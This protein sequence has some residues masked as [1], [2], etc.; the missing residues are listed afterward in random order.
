MP[1]LNSLFGLA[2]AHDTHV[3]PQPTSLDRMFADLQKLGSQPPAPRP[4]A[5]T[6]AVRRVFYSFHYDD[7]F[8]VNHVRNA[9][10][11]RAVDRGRQLTPQDRSLWERVKRTNPANLRRVIDARLQ[12]TSVTCVLV[13]SETWEREWVRYEIARSFFRGNGLLAVHIDKCPCPRNGISRQGANPLAYLALGWDMRIYEHVAGGWYHYSKIQQRMTSWPRWL[14]KP[15]HGRV[16][17]LSEG[18]ASY[19]WKLHDGYRNLLR[20]TDAA[21]KIAGR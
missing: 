3:R 8:R 9:G 10:K 18:T 5:P 12:G 16:M 4:L 2:M 7:V 14:P 21:A 20:W 17:P 19:D 13:G 1:S 6:P 11:I 15:S